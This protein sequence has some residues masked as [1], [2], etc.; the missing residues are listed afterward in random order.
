MENE[1]VVYVPPEVVDFGTVEELTQEN[2]NRG[3]TGRGKVW[4]L[5]AD[6]CTPQF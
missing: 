2:P 6:N 5:E 4:S 1:K 3:R